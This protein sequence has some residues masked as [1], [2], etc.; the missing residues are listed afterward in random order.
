MTMSTAERT[1]RSR[2]HDA[3][4]GFASHHHDSGVFETYGIA[5]WNFRIDSLTTS[6]RLQPPHGN[7]LKIIART[8]PF[9]TF[10]EA[11]AGCERSSCKMVAASVGMK[12]SAAIVI[13]QQGKH[14]GGTDQRLQIHCHVFQTAAVLF[15]GCP[16]NRVEQKH[17]QRVDM[18]A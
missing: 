5:A 3:M 12:K 6:L 8:D 10:Q 14:T 15:I 7:I 16:Q 11:A 2:V 18:I 1:E 13:S 17:V 9:G 4:R